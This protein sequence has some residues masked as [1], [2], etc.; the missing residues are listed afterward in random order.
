MKKIGITSTLPIE[1][2]FAA[3]YT[4][5]DLNN[6]FI[7]NKNADT[8]VA[9]AEKIGFPQ[10]ICCWTKGVFAA[11][12]KNGINEVACVIQGDCINSPELSQ[13]M[14]LFG[15]K[16]HPFSYPFEPDVVELD[17]NIS[18]FAN[19]FGVLKESAEMV[20]KDLDTIRTLQHKIDEMTYEDFK[21]TGF[22]N[23]LY[24]ISSS[25]MM[26]D[27]VIFKKKLEN[28]INDIEPREAKNIDVRLGY[29]GVPPICPDI[30]DYIEELDARIIFNEVQ[31]QFSMPYNTDNLGSQYSKYTYPYQI[32][33]RIKDI[34]EQIAL[35]QLDGLI[36]YSQAFCSRQL[37]DLIFR[38]RLKIPLLTIEADKPGI[39]EP[40]NI[41]KIEAFVDSL[42][43]R[44]RAN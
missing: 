27:P 30:Y 35:R 3:G 23:H 15:M 34:E 5:I 42:I 6:I 8:L 43:K 22:E 32:D 37:D 38:K 41:V 36:H 19:Q 9:E 7:V 16:I 25:D 18:E 4:P 14:E 31:R 44:K 13:V 21:I 29:I 17:K 2:L 26:G 28:F 24:L 1:V 12:M 39:L 33:Y 20:K 11:A 10:T 40:K